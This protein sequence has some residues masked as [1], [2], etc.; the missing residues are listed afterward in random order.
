MLIHIALGANVK[1]FHCIEITDDIPTC[2]NTDSIYR[3][4]HVHICIIL[5][6]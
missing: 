2:L 4:R 6:I 1:I 3:Y 5:F